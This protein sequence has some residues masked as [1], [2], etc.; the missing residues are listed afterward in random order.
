MSIPDSV[1]CRVT[2]HA[3]TAHVDLALPSR[4]PVATLLADVLD[5]MPHQS[6]SGPPRPY[7]LSE[8]GRAALDG[9]KS[10]SQ[11][12]IRDGCTL[13]LTHA[14]CP[15]PK[16]VFDDPAELVAT[17]VLSAQC[18][19]SPVARRLAAALTASGLAAV[20]GFVA[21][22]GGPGAPS[23]LLAAAA[24]GTVA[25]MA[26]PP[27]GC[28]ATLRTTLC[29]LAGLAVLGAVVGMAV[30]ATGIA[31][32]R[33]GAVAAVAGV[34]M[35]RGAG[36]LASAVSGLFRRADPVPSQVGEAHDLLTGWVAAA[37]ALVA[38]GAGATVTA[39]PGAG[40][41]AMVCAAFAAT[42][43]TALVLRSR[44]HTDGVQIA[45]LVTGGTATV[46]IGLLGAAGNTVARWPAVLAVV[47]VA[48]ALALGF[49]ASTASPLIRRSAEVVESLA[50]GSLAPLACWVCG[51]YSLARGLSLG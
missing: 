27:T 20:A 4:L 44:S 51:F 41:P 40:A 31:L 35:T 36:R 1:L 25:L 46:A 13:V 38:V 28:G 24:A 48:A 17:A 32:S 29:C 9:T 6:A 23:A 8:P 3:D 12:G 10:L 15:D 30:A 26:V 39:A 14:E 19:W 5:L 50:L 11:Q 34:A 7:Y 22:P 21:I 16:V 37:A 33:V 18:P 49:T 42:A 45:V 2:V 43:G 47:L